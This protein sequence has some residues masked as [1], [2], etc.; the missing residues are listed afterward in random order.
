MAKTTLILP[1]QNEGSK[2]MRLV[3]EP[4]WEVFLVQPGQKVEIHAVLREDTNNG[5]FTVAPND[6][7][8]VIY[9]PGNAASFVDHYVMLEGVRIQPELED[10]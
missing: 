6:D 8:L 3:L 2:V 10:L 7:F 1:L 9:A 5:F 4:L